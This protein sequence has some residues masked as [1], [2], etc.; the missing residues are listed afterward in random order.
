MAFTSEHKAT[1]VGVVEQGHG[2][3]EKAG[4]VPTGFQTVGQSQPNGLEVRPPTNHLIV[5]SY[6]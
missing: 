2:D 1:D 4:H 5:W 3:I 6:G